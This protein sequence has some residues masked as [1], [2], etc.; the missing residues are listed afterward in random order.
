MSQMVYYFAPTIVLF[1]DSFNNVYL[2][3]NTHFKD[4]YNVE[5]VVW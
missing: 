1:T 5:Y 4:F 2:N 3:N